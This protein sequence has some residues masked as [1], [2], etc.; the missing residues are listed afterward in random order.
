LEEPRVVGAGAGMSVIGADTLTVSGDANTS[1]TLTYARSPETMLELREKFRASNKIIA[2]MYERMLNPETRHSERFARLTDQQYE[3]S[4]NRIFVAPLRT[5]VIRFGDDYQCS[6]GW[7]ST[8]RLEQDTPPRRTDAPRPVVENGVYQLGKDKAG[9]L[10]LHTQFRRVEET[11]LWCGDG[12]KGHIPLGT[13]TQN[14]WSHWAPTLPAATVDTA[15]PWTA[16]PRPGAVDLLPSMETLRNG[17]RSAST[18]SKPVQTTSLEAFAARIA[19]LLPAGVAL[20][21]TIAAAGGY[22]VVV[23]A[24]AQPQ[25]SQLLR[26]IQVSPT[27]A[28]P[29]LV[30]TFKNS[31]NGRIE[32]HIFV[33]EKQRN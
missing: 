10:V 25:I 33:F 23:F 18:E 20:D 17:P 16:Q 30:K 15:R 14:H 3:D 21:S 31:G 12:C 13:W 7:L 8:P 27:F 1:L 6:G 29:D 32:A 26:N 28:T 11:W 24:D 2:D 9:H 22:K 19:P 4:L 5:R